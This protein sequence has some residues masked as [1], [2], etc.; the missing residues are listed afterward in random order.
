MVGIAPI[1][2]AIQDLLSQHGAL[3]PSERRE[4][5][6]FVDHDEYG[7]ALQTWADI[8]REEGRGVPEAVKSCA[9]L[10]AERMRIDPGRL[11]DG[12]NDRL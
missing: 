6:H 12:T 9:I 7:L 3:T 8:V 4:I 10:I 2:E 1:D 11:F 5:L